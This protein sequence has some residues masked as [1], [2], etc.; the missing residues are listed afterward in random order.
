MNKIFSDR[1]WE[2]YT[3]FLKED[4][5]ILKR[6]HELLKDIDRN[7]HEGIGKPEPLRHNFSGY[8][9]PL[10]RTKYSY[11]TI[12]LTN[13]DSTFLRKNDNDFIIKIYYQYNE[14]IIM[15]KVYCLWGNTPKEVYY[16]SLPKVA[17][18]D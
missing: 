17:S 10:P 8:W 13:G 15:R 11:P 2:E 9:R 12:E 5:K 16:F 3:S 18:F 1:A 7:G 14:N 6:I 4:K